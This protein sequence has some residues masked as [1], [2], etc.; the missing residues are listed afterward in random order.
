MH[1]T[2]ARL[3]AFLLLTG[4]MLTECSTDHRRHRQRSFA[5]LGLRFDELW[6]AVNPLQLFGDSDIPQLEIHGVPGQSERFAL[7]ESHRKSH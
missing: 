5:S 4:E 6:R 3:L 1:P 7:S 2:T